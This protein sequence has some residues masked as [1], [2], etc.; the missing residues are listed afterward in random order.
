MAFQPRGLIRTP[1][2]E[3]LWKETRDAVLDAKET[4]TSEFWEDVLHDVFIRQDSGYYVNAQQPPKDGSSKYCDFIVSVKAAHNKKVRLI[5]VE[6]KRL[7]VSESVS[8]MQALE[9][10]LREY[11]TAAAE[12]SLIEYGQFVYGLAVVGTR[13]RLY[14]F[15]ASGDLRHHSHQFEV[16][17][18]G[19]GD[20]YRDAEEDIWHEAFTEIKRFPPG[21]GYAIPY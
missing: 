18:G 1:S 7:R 8:R 12:S 16:G 11:C 5:V 4:K 2:K 20:G 14:T 15:D 13:G 6:A 21:G 3:E 10:Q 19:N 17:A 9:T